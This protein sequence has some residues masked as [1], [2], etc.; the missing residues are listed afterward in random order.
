M[1][2]TC[3]VD[4]SILTVNRVRLRHIVRDTKHDA[5]QT[6]VATLHALACLSQQYGWN[7]WNSQKVEFLQ[8]LP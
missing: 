6:R 5:T 8:A 2:D 4:F 1:P 3:K 7:S